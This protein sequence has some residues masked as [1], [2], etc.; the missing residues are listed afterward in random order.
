[1]VAGALCLMASLTAGAA[2]SAKPAPETTEVLPG[3]WRIRFGAP[4]AATPTAFRGAEPNAAG[5]AALPKAA[6]PPLDPASLGISIRPRGCTL[7]IPLAKG[8]EIYGLGLQGDTFR[9]RGMKRWLMNNCCVMAKMGLGH[10]SFPYYV[11]SR[12]Y[13]VLIDTARYTTIYC[14]TH[15]KQ[16]M[17]GVKP[18]KSV[19]KP[20]AKKE[21]ELLPE[22]RNHSAGDAGLMA[23][24]IPAAQGIDVY[25]F[26][27]PG[28]RAAIQ[29]YNLFSG[30]G[31]LP[32]LWGLGVKHRMG[33]TRNQEQVLELARYFRDRKLPCDEIALEPVWMARAHPCTWTWNER[34]FPH[35]DALIAELHKM[36][37]QF[38][39]WEHPYIDVQSP[40][41]KALK[42]YSCDYLVFPRG[43]LVPDFATEKGRAIY[44]D[45]HERELI[46][47]GVDGFKIDAA[48]QRAFVPEQ[49]WAF[50]DCARFPSGLD[51]EQMHQLFG[52]LA[53]RTLLEPF[54][55]LN[56]RTWG[57]VRCSGAL[58]A[59]YPYSLFSDM[60]D[61][62][63]YVR[64]IITGGFCGLLWQ[65]EVR[66][67]GTIDQLLSLIQTD[68]M[69]P[70]L[71]FNSYSIDSTPW[72][73]LD[74]YKNKQK[75][76][77]PEEEIVA[78][79]ARVR[80]LLEAR[81]SLVP[82]LYSAFS[83]YQREGLPP[84]RALVVDYPGDP[85][86]AAIDN[87][88]MMGDCMLAAPTI[89]GAHQ[90][91]VYFPANTKWVCFNTGRVYEGGKSYKIKMP[92]DELPLFVKYGSVVPVAEPLQ[93]IAA[94]AVFRVTCRVFGPGPGSFT[95]IEDDGLTYDYLA[96]LQNRV[97]LGW[98]GRQG[99]VRREGNYRGPQRYKIDAWRRF[100]APSP[101]ST[102]AGDS[103]RL[104]PRQI[105]VLSRSLK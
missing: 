86:V 60:G 57:E 80:R 9:Q 45:L 93:H 22:E 56:R 77:Y 74:P 66:H 50:P 101:V 8:E 13:A 42:P 64:M 35:P 62:E 27:G 36:G 16:D 20:K 58:A 14:G 12:G 49:A 103:A 68:A 69:S 88:Y 21:Q 63:M 26:A 81:M 102:G 19:S 98:D 87:E 95:L 54:R 23:V 40:M 18:A 37:Y 52:T 89:R 4:E 76:L 51:G 105:P 65:P 41:Y 78:H 79:E 90:R 71:C 30:G 53:Q 29:R 11:S 7:D 104:E 38:D 48:D 73:Q 59:C 85:A 6:K 3:I 1:M 97:E 47:K 25:V 44:A 84:F 43:G 92:L 10:A 28:M 2:P 99:S 100:D 83:R 82:Y 34:A 39:L 33:E 31:V 46:D 96:G 17:P 94:D 32:P 24:D 72:M 55:K 61:H 91:M 75:I 15:V 70:N 67:R 5:L